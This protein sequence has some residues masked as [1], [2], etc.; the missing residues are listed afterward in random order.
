MPRY[1]MLNKPYDVQSQFSGDD[2]TR[3]LKGYVGIPDV[4]PVG[5]LDM[6]SEGLL[7]LTDDGGLAHRLTDPR[8]EH[9]KTYW[10]QVERVPDERALRQLCAGVVIEGKRT[11]PAEFRLLEEP[12]AL[13]ERSKPV[14]FRKNVP[15]AWLEVV[16]REGRNRQI[17]KMT[18]AVGF[19]TLRI[20]RVGHGPLRLGDLPVGAWRELGGDEVEQLKALTRQPK[21]TGGKLRPRG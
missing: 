16:L 14:R 20:F 18:A 13:P 1:L 2:P 15:T 12:P 6:D 7:L 3:T 4:Y 17:R 9:P 19:P 11:R 21:Q 8:Y 5:R 10:V